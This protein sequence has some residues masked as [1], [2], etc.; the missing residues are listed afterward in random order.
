MHT[1]CLGVASSGHACQL[2]ALQPIICSILHLC[3]VLCVFVYF[4]IALVLAY[5][6]RY[7]DRDVGCIREFFKRRFNYESEL[8][9]KFSDV[10]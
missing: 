5:I 3:H 9:P 4:C 7:F 6:Y 8:F 1:H 10:T 2:V